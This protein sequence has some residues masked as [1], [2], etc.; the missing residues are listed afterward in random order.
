MISQ[1]MVYHPD[2]D[3]ESVYSEQSQPNEHTV[4]ALE[5]SSSTSTSDNDETSLPI[6]TMSQCSDS[7]NVS[8]QINKV[9]PT[10]ETMLPQPVLLSEAS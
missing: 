7:S 4:F 9:S 10:S 1:L 6:F 3:T 5:D 2:S 8:L